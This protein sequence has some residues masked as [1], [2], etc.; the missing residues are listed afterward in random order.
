MLTDAQAR[1]LD[2]AWSSARADGALGSATLEELYDHAAGFVPAASV[3][4]GGTGARA[5]RDADPFRDGLACVDVGTGAGVPGV[6]LAVQHPSWHWRLVD[7]SERRCEFAWRAVRALQLGSRV[8]VVH[9]RVDELAHVEA[10]RG[11][12]DLVTARL[13]G[14]PAE[15]AECAL[16]IVADGGHLVVSVSAA[17]VGRWRDAD[18]AALG[19]TVV[20]RWETVAGSGVTGSF[21]AVRR[22]GPLQDRYPRRAAKRR[23]APLF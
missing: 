8:E 3:V 14:P 16:P 20:A 7:A 10:W 18:L 6:L 15:V 5:A 12:A 17:T 19:A 23:R 21:V 13:F 11:S 2:A 1:A 22:S 9:G 4:F